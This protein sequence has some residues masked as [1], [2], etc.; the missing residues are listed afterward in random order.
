MGIELQRTQRAQSGYENGTPDLRG[1]ARFAQWLPAI[2]QRANRCVGAGCGRF[3][4]AICVC[5]REIILRH[6]LVMAVSWF[7]GRSCGRVA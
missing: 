4:R 7:G 1:L 5:A 6:C 3:G 2:A